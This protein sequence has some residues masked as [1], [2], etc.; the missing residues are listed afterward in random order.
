M[1]KFKILLQVIE[2]VAIKPMCLV[3]AE[4]VANNVTGLKPTTLS[5]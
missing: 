1:P 2:T 4:M 3:T 5:L